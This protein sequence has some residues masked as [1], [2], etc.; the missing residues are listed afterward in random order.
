M[1]D[2][3]FGFFDLYIKDEK[4]N[5]LA[6]FDGKAAY[7]DAHFFVHIIHI[8]N[9]YYRHYFYFAVNLLITTRVFLVSVLRVTRSLGGCCFLF[10]LFFF[11]C[12]AL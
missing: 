12:E 6:S 10:F 8:I 3:T 5:Y 2:D 7:V 11:F 1:L 4:K 9:M